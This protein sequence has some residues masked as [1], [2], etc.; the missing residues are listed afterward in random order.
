MAKCMLCHSKHLY[1]FSKEI[2]GFRSFRYNFQTHVAKNDENYV[3]GSKQGG[4]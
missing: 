2:K 3:E 4:N 1:K